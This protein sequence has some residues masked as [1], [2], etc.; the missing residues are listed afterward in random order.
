MRRWLS[1]WDARGDRW[2]LPAHYRAGSRGVGITPYVRLRLIGGISQPVRTTARRRAESVARFDHTRPWMEMAKS[3]GAV[4]GRRRGTRQAPWRDA[5][6]G[7]TAVERPNNP[8]MAPSPTVHLSNIEQVGS[9]RPNVTFGPSRKR[10]GCHYRCHSR[11]QSF[12]SWPK[13][14]AGILSRSCR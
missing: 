5:A 6:G 4:G 9:Q 14:L 7:G 1:R 12:E 11:L 8:P 13:P 2:P 3:D 10:E